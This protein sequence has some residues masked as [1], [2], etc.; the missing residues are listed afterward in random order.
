M[1]DKI[2][3]KFKELFYY[4]KEKKRKKKLVASIHRPKIAIKSV[5]SPLN[6]HHQMHFPTRLLFLMLSP[7]SLFCVTTCHSV[8]FLTAS[9]SI[10]EISGNSTALLDLYL[11]NS[12]AAAQ[13][14]QTKTS[15]Q[16]FEITSVN[17]ISHFR[18]AKYCI[19]EDPV[20]IEAKIRNKL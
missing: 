14:T 9:G 12:A 17:L 10:L 2:S 8:L 6:S 1:A 3:F 13:F 15:P 5:F 7:F 16:Q 20:A 18:K 19:F 11:P 4:L